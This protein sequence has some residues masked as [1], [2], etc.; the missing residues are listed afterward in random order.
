LAIEIYPLSPSFGAAIRGIKLESLSEKEWANICS[1]FLQFAVLIFPE[2]MLTQRQQ[3]SF[4]GRFGSIEHLVEGLKTIPISNKTPDGSFFEENSDRLKLLKG[5]EGWHTDSSYMHIT[6]KAS[7]LSAHVVPSNGGETEW[8]DMR[9]AYEAL[10]VQTK[11]RIRDLKAYHSFFQSQARV[12]HTVEV[13]AGYGFFHGEPP[14]HRL[15]KIHPETGREALFI[16]RHAFA[17]P[18]YPLEEAEELLQR[19]MNFACQMPRVL[20]HCW[21]EG[22]LVVWDN[23]CVLH[24]AMPYNMKEERFMLHT[25]IAGDP[26]TERSL[27]A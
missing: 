26:R 16:G 7:V 6:A 2:Q 5:N 8:A 13:G 17:I 18:D 3:E 21:R 9:A 15:V 12:G 14:L 22:D 27:N 10:D 20:R 4:A 23:R 25:R 19:L 1:S 24:R 11:V